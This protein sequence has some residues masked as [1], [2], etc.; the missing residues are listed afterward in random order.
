MAIK[1]TTQATKSVPAEPTP[2]AP[3]PPEAPVEAPVADADPVQGK[4]DA[5]S[6]KLT[7]LA[8]TI[9]ELQAVVKVLQKDYVKSVK[10]ASKRTRKAVAGG[11]KR[12]PSGFAKPAKL[13]NEL[14][15][16]L[17]IPHGSER[18]RTE[19]TRMLNQYIKTKNL[20]DPNDKRNIN[21]D[22]ALKKIMNLTDSVKLTYFNLQTYIKHHFVPAAKA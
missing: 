18:A 12:T 7:L 10:T 19:V 1:K 8:N 3:A 17:S 2:A 16:F 21:P 20:Q 6:E 14:C 11:A 9:K 4:L 5:V 22:P 13:S 15:D